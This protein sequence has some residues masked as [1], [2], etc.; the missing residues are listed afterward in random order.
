MEAKGRKLVCGL[1]MDEM[2]IK[3]DFHY[4]NNRMQGYVNLGL[5]TE[6]FDGLPMA[7]E[8][9]VFMIVAL[10][11]RWKVPIAYF[12]INGI[13]AQERGNLVNM[14]LTKISD[15]G[16]FDRTLTFDGIAANFSMAHFLGADLSVHSNNTF[17]KHPV[18]NYNIHIF[19]DAAH[20]SKL[21][22]NTLGDWKEIHDNTGNLIKWEYFEKLVSIQEGLGLHLA[23]KIRKRH[24]QFYKE[25]M[26]VRLA[27]QTFS[28]S[29]ADAMIYCKN[30]LQLNDFNDS[31]STINFCNQ[32]NN[33][34]DFL[35]TRNHLSRA[36]YKKPLNFWDNIN[37]QQ[38][39]TR[40]IS[41]L[42]NLKCKDIKK[43]S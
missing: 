28:Q 25:K 9:L 43:K 23:T 40:S 2:Y 20:M 37:I 24:I 36:E 16:A 15:T 11:S 42:K 31:A 34:F 29:V 26:K 12:L 32:I 30:N 17:F 13:S 5:N 14:C 7:K 33:I 8:A 41:Y 39:I 6:H 27:S 38:F 1:L 35:N 22:R 3:E 18:T 19:L 10:N 21:V 4:N